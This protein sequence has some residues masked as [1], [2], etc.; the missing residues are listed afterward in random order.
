MYAQC[1]HFPLIWVWDPC[2]HANISTRCVQVM[3]LCGAKKGA[4]EC[5]EA[6]DKIDENILGFQG[7]VR[8]C[9]K[10]TKYLTK[11][12][13]KYNAE[14]MATTFAM[15]CCGIAFLWSSSLDV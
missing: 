11:G 9:K 8:E 4:F 5:T 15:R 3:T 6:T 14:V 2:T 1:P 12:L 10:F 7:T 13:A